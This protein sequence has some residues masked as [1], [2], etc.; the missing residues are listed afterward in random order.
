MNVQAWFNQTVKHHFETGHYVA[1]EIGRKDLQAIGYFVLAF[2]RAIVLA[3]EIIA[4]AIK[5]SKR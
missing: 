2:C 5:E 4:E 1:N 3:A